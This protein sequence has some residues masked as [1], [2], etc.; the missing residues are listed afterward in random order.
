MK[1]RTIE[2]K[3]GQ[4]CKIDNGTTGMNVEGPAVILI[5]EDLNPAQPPF[6]TL[7]PSAET[8]SS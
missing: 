2:V 1:T 6:V 5:V 4:T 3:S 7:T 8:K